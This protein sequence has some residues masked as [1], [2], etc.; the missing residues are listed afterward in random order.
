M[1]MSPRLL[2]PRASSALV[3]TDADARAYI[4]AVRTA[5]G[6][7]Y[8][9]VAVQ[10]AIDAFITGCKADGIWTAIKAS[11]LLMG[12]R[13]LSGALTPLV[14]TAPTNNGP[15]VSGDYNRKT[16]LIGNGT[17]KFL[18]SNRN[19]NADPQDSHHIAVYVSTAP[20]GNMVFS[21]AGAASTGSTQFGTNGTAI[22]FRN[23]NS[24]V[25][26]VSGVASSTGFIGMSRGQSSEFIARVGG[27]T[28][29]QSRTS[30]SPFNGNILVYARNNATNTAGIFSDARI[31]FYSIGESLLLTTFESRVTTLYNAI[32]AAIP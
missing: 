30:E 25:N 24:L 16:G 9:E 21:G 7:Q 15:F 26:S 2:R 3:A 1:A 12:A 17:T 23:R 31:A 8:M 10:R 18:N 14:G 32:G 29:T 20:T 4:N 22:E 6:G 13:S 28:Y 11:C 5:D 27:V 19:S